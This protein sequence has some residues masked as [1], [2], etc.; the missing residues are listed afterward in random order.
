ML[1][2]TFLLQG[3]FL[4]DGRILERKTGRQSPVLGLKLS[5]LTEQILN[6]SSPYVLHQLQFLSSRQKDSSM[7]VSVKKT[8]VPSCAMDFMPGD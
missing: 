7:M 5:D 3:V 8:S 6:L 2:F 1:L 4:L